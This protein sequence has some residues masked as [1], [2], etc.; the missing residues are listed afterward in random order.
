MTKIDLE[1]PA[2]KQQGET[3]KVPVG[4]QGWGRLL[5]IRIA[6]ILIISVPNAPQFLLN[7]ACEKM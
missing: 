6:V 3:G 7:P 4:E 1:S 5:S 2:A